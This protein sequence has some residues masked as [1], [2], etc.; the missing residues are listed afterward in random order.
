MAIERFRLPQCSYQELTKIIKAYG[1]LSKPASL[2]EASQ[3]LGMDTTV[4]S[5]NVGFL[6]AVGILEAGSKK[7]ATEIGRSLS[8]ALEHEMEDETT[9]KWRQISEEDEF[10][11]KIVT[12]VRIR[13]GMDQ[14]TLEAHIAYSAGQPKKKAFMTGA[15]SVIDI[16]L[17]ARLIRNEDGKLIAIGQDQQVADLGQQGNTGTSS[18]ALLSPDIQPNQENEQQ[19]SCHPQVILNINVDCKPDD[20]EN[21]GARIKQILKDLQADQG[22]SA[23]GA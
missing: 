10:L 2:D 9:K 17:S 6:V 19:G 14:G 16:L 12:A 13:K 11:S 21:L 3:L 7:I 5:R 20:L 4:I 23:Q 15:R 8:Q 22:S 18:D 1:Q